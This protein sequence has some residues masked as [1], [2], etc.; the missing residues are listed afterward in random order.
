MRAVIREFVSRC[1]ALVGGRRSD[2]QLSDEIRLHLELLATDFVRRGMTP[3]EARAA[4]RRE[5]GGVDQGKEVY[6]DQRGWPWL[7][8]LTQDTRYAVRS[9]RR[10][11]LFC[12]IAVVTLALGIGATTA[13]FGG[14]K[15]VLL[16]PLP[17][18]EADRV[19]EIIETTPTGARNAGTFGMFSG[20]ADRTRSF[21]A[22]AVM[23]A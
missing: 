18:A 9:L 15:A 1:L 23:K 17:Y 16:E 4:A 6:R 5:F 19:A 11:Q 3:A 13:I 21:E 8:A 14:V 2:A 10:D 20:L 22:M 7:D 12:A